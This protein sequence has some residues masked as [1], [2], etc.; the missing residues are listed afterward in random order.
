MAND[1][2]YTEIQQRTKEIY[3]DQHKN[4]YVDDTIFQRHFNHAVD[5]ESYDLTADFFVGK[6]VLDA[7]CGNSGYFQV[8]M[9][10]L[11]AR[12]VTCLDIGGGVATGS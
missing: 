8:A 4:Y 5:P 12:K 2:K 1:T 9:H 6:H 3:I 7:G 11:G 10:R